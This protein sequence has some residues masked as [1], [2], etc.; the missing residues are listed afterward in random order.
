MLEE[1]SAEGALQKAK[2]GALWIKAKKRIRIWDKKEDKR[3]KMRK[4][5]REKRKRKKKR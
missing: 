3:K 4:E 5:K 2:G 1:C